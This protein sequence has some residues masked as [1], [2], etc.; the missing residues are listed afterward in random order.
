MCL[1]KEQMGQILNFVMTTGNNEM[2]E[3]IYSIYQHTKPW[4]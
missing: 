1:C 4:F 2:T 3:A